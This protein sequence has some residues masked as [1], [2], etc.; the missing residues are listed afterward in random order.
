V[1][2][3]LAKRWWPLAFGLAAVSA[4]ALPAAAQS[5]GAAEFFNGIGTTR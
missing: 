2:D 3:A 5:G 4:W 1:T